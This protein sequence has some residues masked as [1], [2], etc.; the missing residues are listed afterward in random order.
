LVPTLFFGTL[1]IMVVYVT[2]SP[3]VEVNTYIGCL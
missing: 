3:Y 2:T 1:F